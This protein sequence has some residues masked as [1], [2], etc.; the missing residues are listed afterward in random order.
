MP[1][2]PPCALNNLTNTQKSN[3]RQKPTRHLKGNGS[4]KMLASTVQFSTNNQ[5]PPPPAPPARPP[6]R[7]RRCETRD[8][9]APEKAPATAHPRPRV[10]LPQDPTACLR[11]RF[12]PTTHVPRTP[13]GAV[14][15]GGQDTGGRTGQRS[16]LEHHPDNPR[17]ITAIHR[18][19]AGMALD[20]H[21][22][23]W[24]ASCSLER[25]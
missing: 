11:P 7:S 14:L 25:R 4:E 9:P 22:C 23:G 18:S 20:R 16:T 8:G 6:T 13:G 12:H 15:A 19:R 17:R 5:P 2:H 21:P 24:P 1:R 10:P 3:S